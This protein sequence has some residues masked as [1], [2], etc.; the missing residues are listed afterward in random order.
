MQK[1]ETGAA[2]PRHMARQQGKAVCDLFNTTK[3]NQH[4]QANPKTGRLKDRT[5][6]FQTVV[7]LKKRVLLPA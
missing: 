2:V 3:R 5:G 4:P 7:V 1:S 6:E